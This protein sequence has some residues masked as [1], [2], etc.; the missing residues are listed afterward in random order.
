MKPRVAIVDDHTLLAE[1]FE[2][3]LEPDCE[4]VGSYNDARSFLVEAV[5][6]KP[7]VV[8]LDVSMPLM[9]GLDAARELHRLVPATR[10]IFLTM[11]EDPDVAAEA[12]RLGA[13]GYLLK[14]SAGSELPFAV[15]EVMSHRYYITPLLTKELMGTLMREPHIP[16]PAHQLTARQREVLQ[17]L[18]EGRSMKE[19]AAI[20]NVSARTVAFH[21]Y[22][23][24]E[25]LHV[26]STA[27]LIQFA[28]REGFV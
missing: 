17:L 20:L 25:H 16:K 19:A 24:M 15:R 22:R 26:H 1:A 12:F 4:V 28:V 6:L 2:K 27:A 3:L 18:A 21:K 10:I 9:N 11:N 14:R 7:D 5:R 23:M 8:I 13:W